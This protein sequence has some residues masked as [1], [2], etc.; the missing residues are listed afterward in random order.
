MSDV[1]QAFVTSINEP[2]PLP[3]MKN[4]GF[5]KVA[6]EFAEALEKLWAYAEKNAL[7]R[8]LDPY[9]CTSA[10]GVQ[11]QQFYLSLKARRRS[12]SSI[13]NATLAYRLFANGVRGNIDLDRDSDKIGQFEMNG[14]LFSAYQCLQ[15]LD[16]PEAGSAISARCGDWVVRGPDSTTRV[17][18]NIEFR[19]Y[20]IPSTQPVE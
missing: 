4:D 2:K 15:S 1:G 18:P 9:T 12:T 11:N 13:Y 3:P 20:F 5:Y 7:A 19:T 16:V 14:G 17:I 8:P 6:K 10:I